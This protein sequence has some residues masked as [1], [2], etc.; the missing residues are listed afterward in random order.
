MHT[1]KA[2]KRFS[3]PTLHT[4]APQGVN[5]LSNVNSA[6]GG[7]WASEAYSGETC[8]DAADDTH[9]IGES[10]ATAPLNTCTLSTSFIAS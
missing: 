8:R 3:H 6:Q 2:V 1:E 9:L 10:F 4:V 7:A 5:V